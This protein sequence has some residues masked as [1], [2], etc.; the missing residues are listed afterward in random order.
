MKNIKKVAALFVLV[1]L[2]G[3]FNIS[4]A[5][6]LNSNKIT[7]RALVIGNDRYKVEGASTLTGAVNDALKVRDLLEELEVSKEKIEVKINIDLTGQQIYSGIKTRFK[8]N[9]EN[10][11]SYIYYSGHGTLLEG[12]SAIVGVDMAGLT[13][14]QLKE[15]LDGLKGKFI[16]MIDA[17]NSGGFVEEFSKYKDDGKYKI[18][19]AAGK[20]EL[21]K[22][23]RED[24]SNPREAMSGVFTRFLT[25]G[26]TGKDRIIGDLNENGE[27][28][29]NELYR[30]TKENVYSS[31]VQVYPKRDNYLLLIKPI[32]KFDRSSILDGETWREEFIDSNKDKYLEIEFDEK[33]D[34]N[35]IK[36][37]MYILDN[38][39]F[40]S[41]ITDYKIIKD[42]YAI[43][44][45]DIS[46]MQKDRSY[47]L[48]IGKNFSSKDEIHGKNLLI[49]LKSN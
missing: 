28:S 5:E 46:E 1:G 6:D 8:D 22:E 24:K 33:I 20:H 30:Y 37:N 23:D 18:I 21:A 3:S 10:D 11:I 49:K 25:K 14:K 48:V 29:L 26:L 42:G 12:Q 35:S 45:Y 44:I 41:L 2:M 40:K 34:E 7:H 17:C 32:E 31:T 27:L 36:N 16:I 47:D 43:E 38:N 9:D 4:Y 19:T 39:N 13:A 15:N